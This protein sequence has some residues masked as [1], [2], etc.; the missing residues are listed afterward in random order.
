MT[1][2][3]FLAPR[4][5]WLDGVLIAALLVGANAL[6]ARA[7]PGWLGLNPTPYVLLPVLL[8]A[9]YGF[10]AGLGGA[11]AV[12]AGIVAVRVG[13]GRVADARS[14]LAATPYFYVSLIVLGAVSGEVWIYFRRRIAQLEA[15]DSVIRTKLRRLDS[16]AV[17]LREAKD[18]LDR[19]T[20]ARDGEISSFDAELRRLYA[21]PPATLPAEILQLLKRQARVADAALY[22]VPEGDP[23]EETWV[24]FA[25][26]GREDHLPPELDLRR[27]AMADRAYRSRSLVTLP[28]IETHTRVADQRALMAAP[29][30]G[31]DGKARAL[32]VVA[33]MP[34]IAFT[35]AAANLI[36]LVASWSG[37]VLELA[38]GAP[39]RYRI[40]AG[41]ES[42][43]V[44]FEPQFR[45]LA[46]LAHEACQRHRLPSALVELSLPGEPKAG[47]AEF[48]RV[49]LG[50]VRSGDFVMEPTRAYPA[51]VV[52]LPLA[53]ERGTDIFIDRCSQFC[54]RNGIADEAMRV[55]RVDLSTTESAADALRELADSK[56][57]RGA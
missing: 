31:A 17:V 53:G 7:D 41:R 48:E 45:H 4:Q 12:M 5:V 29:L 26:I 38:E 30:P 28:E 2:R 34:F 43:R 16:D 19:I 8:G 56:G 21:C 20:A 22:R 55:A 14:A 47:Q 6:L 52:L 23:T 42:Q 10:G 36:G 44:F 1:L 51:L 50:A 37:G 46:E 9:R 27:H 33:D 11:L 39:G 3:S 32:L 18:E 54:R 40:V 25:T 15:N 13:T 57:A 24:R 35:P 49:V